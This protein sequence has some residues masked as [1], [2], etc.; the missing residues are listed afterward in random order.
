MIK[1]AK[2]YWIIM[3]LMSMGKLRCRKAGKYKSSF[4]NSDS[5]LECFEVLWSSGIPMK[6]FI[7]I[8][9]R[10]NIDFQTRIPPLSSL[11]SCCRIE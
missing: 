2:E 7:L 5:I 8:A 1:Y 3:L 6:E 9:D 11:V 10:I 4:K